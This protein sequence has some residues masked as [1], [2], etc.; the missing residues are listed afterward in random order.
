VSAGREGVV[1]FR[2]GS[3][4]ISPQE[5]LPYDGISIVPKVEYDGTL[6]KIKLLED[7]IQV[8]W[9]DHVLSLALSKSN[10][11]ALKANVVAKLRLQLETSEHELNTLNEKVQLSVSQNHSE[12]DAIKDQHQRTLHSVR[13]E[14]EKKLTAERRITEQFIKSCQER[15]LMSEGDLVTLSDAHTAMMDKETR[16]LHELVVEENARKQELISAI[17]VLVS[18]KSEYEARIEEDADRE[19][20]EKNITY[21][22]QL[23]SLKQSNTLLR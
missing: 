10:H 15:R 3:G 14:G 1:T 18:R 4:K 21:Q 11:D 5:Y 13:E 23:H 19:M 2:R 9:S 17:N 12:M 22:K 8:L 7:A 16:T 6:D 20:V